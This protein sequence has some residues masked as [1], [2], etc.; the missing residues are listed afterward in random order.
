M[1][2]VSAKQ[3]RDI[4]FTDSKMLSKL[5]TVKAVSFHE[6]LGFII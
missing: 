4:S 1:V 6:I 2:I 3:L 5:T